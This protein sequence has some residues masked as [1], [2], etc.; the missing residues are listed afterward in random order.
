MVAE[1]FP[2]LEDF[3]LARGGAF[4]LAPVAIRLREVAA[5]AVAVETFFLVLLLIV[6]FLA[7]NARLRSEAVFFL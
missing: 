7:R 6:F 3:V 1:V 5:S 4:F 2:L